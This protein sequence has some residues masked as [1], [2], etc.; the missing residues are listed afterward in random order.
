MLS[1]TI[2]RQLSSLVSQV[3]VLIARVEEDVPADEVAI[4]V[5]AIGQVLDDL[6]ENVRAGPTGAFNSLARHLH[7]LQR[8]PRE[9]VADGQMAHL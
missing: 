1:I 6:Q 5:A 7:W 8:Y 2:Y 3:H 9:Q 4:R